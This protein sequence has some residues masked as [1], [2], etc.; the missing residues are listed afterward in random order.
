M[1]SSTPDLSLHP[2]LRAGRWVILLALAIAL[3]PGRHRLIDPAG[4][5]SLAVALLL[6]T[7][8]TL[9]LLR[10]PKLSLARIAAIAL[11]DDLVITASDR[12]HRRINT[13]CRKMSGISLIDSD[14]TDRADVHIVVR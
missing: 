9:A 10:P 8:G 13:R 3:L 4:R 2:L 1:T 6:Y 7:L 11:S 12:Q 5:A 14:P